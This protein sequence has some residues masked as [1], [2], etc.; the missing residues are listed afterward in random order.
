MATRTTRRI[1]DSTPF[2]ATT[3][4]TMAALSLAAA[5]GM[6]WW[7]DMPLNFDVN[8]PSFNPAVFVPLA[9]T[10]YG[11]VQSARFLRAR[12]IGQRF[13]ASVF[14]MQGH[15]VAVG[16]TLRG[17]VMTARDLAAPG[18]F[19]L[20]LR[21]IEEVRYADQAGGGRTGSRADRIRW[22]ATDT[23]QAA[24]SSSE[25]V[26]VHFDIPATAT[27]AVVESGPVRWILEVEAT[28]DG[29]RYEALFGV[30]ITT[31]ADD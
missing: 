20:R 10:A 6:V 21:C 5:V 16:G 2:H 12:R 26:P 25:G 29:A 19:R 13:G 11:V 9:L 4:W 18:G 1:D 30:P 15:A 17:Q 3:D 23:V 31:P 22:E 27:A 7:F 28:V 24:A 14:E 8:S